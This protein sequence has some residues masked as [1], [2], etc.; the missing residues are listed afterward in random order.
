MLHVLTDVFLV[1]SAKS[2]VPGVDRNDLHEVPVAIPP[3]EEQNA[4]AR[5]LDDEVRGFEQLSSRVGS[6]IDRLRE[7]R[8]A[9]IS[10]AVTGKIDVRGEV[11]TQ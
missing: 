3:D 10:A 4:I 7:Y 9:L 11:A 8:S 6:A 2:A 1:N 5:Y